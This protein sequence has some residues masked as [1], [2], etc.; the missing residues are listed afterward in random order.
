MAD[1][2]TWRPGF[3]TLLAPIFW[4][5]DDQE[6]IVRA[7]LAITAV[8][9]GL[10]AIVL[11]HLALRI[12]Q[13]SPRGSTLIA[14]VVALTPVSMAASA[15]L[16]AEP[17]VTLIFLCTVLALMRFFDH[18]R[19]DVGALAVALSIAGY[20]SHGRLLPLV[21]TTIICTAGAFA[22]LR[23][24]RDSS[25]LLVL[26]I[27]LMSASEWYAGWFYDALWNDPSEVNTVGGVLDRL[28]DP[29]GVG[30]AGDRPVVV[31][32][33]LD[34]WSVRRRYRRPDT[35][36]NTPFRGSADRHR[37]A[38]APRVHA[39]TDC[40]LGR[41]HDEPRANRSADLRTLQRCRGLASSGDRG[42]VVRVARGIALA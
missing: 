7:G 24:W 20:T 5:T 10:S 23:R 16:W 17:L 29:I 8:L 18:P 41:L 4:F 27:V 13:L 42:G 6:T 19:L 36:R 15:Y 33:G 28:A 34:R 31:S 21:L 37:C 11:A 3:P 9:A 14:G 39:A 12:T 32:P 2:R 25:L 22:R 26:T 38:R 1:A 40:T 35:T 30:L